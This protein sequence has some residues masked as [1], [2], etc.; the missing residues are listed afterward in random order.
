MWEL[1]IAT[2]LA[3][4]AAELRIDVPRAMR[5]NR[6]GKRKRC[7]LHVEAP[8]CHRWLTFVFGQMEKLTFLKFTRNC[9]APW[10][11]WLGTCEVLGNCSL[12][13]SWPGSWSMIKM[14]ILSGEFVLYRTFLW[15]L[16]SNNS[17]W[18]QS[19]FHF[20]SGI[21]HLRSWSLMMYITTHTTT[22]TLSLWKLFP[23]AGFVSIF[24]EISSCFHPI[25]WK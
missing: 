18:K 3:T 22:S 23:S 1:L 11:S 8:G 10:I 5:V 20:V 19:S 2:I 15:N 13:C 24:I 9:S 16:R 7:T 21:S 4:S 17:Y 12:A 14:N 6:L 25:L